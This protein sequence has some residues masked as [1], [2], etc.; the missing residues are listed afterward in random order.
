MLVNEITNNNLVV[1]GF[2][3]LLNSGRKLFVK[4]YE[5]NLDRYVK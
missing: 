5:R 3:V 2:N 4:M 1:Y